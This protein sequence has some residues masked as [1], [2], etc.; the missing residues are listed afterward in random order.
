VTEEIAW[1]LKR[2]GKATWDTWREKMQ[3]EDNHLIL[4]GENNRPN[5][6]VRQSAV[7]LSVTAI[8]ERFSWMG[9]RSGYDQLYEHW[10]TPEQIVSIWRRSRRGYT[11]AWQIAG[12]L[13]DQ[14]VAGHWYDFS[15]VVAELR[16][17]LLNHHSGINVVHYTYLE[18]QLGHFCPTSKSK[19]CLVVATAHQPVSWWESHYN[20][21]HKLNTVDALIVLSTPALKF[22]E[23][24]LPG[25]V[26]LIR[27]GVD[28][29]F[30]H[31][32]EKIDDVRNGTCRCVFSG[33]WLRDLPT[34]AQVIRAFSKEDSRVHF[35]LIVRN[36]SEPQLQSLLALKNVKL[37]REITDEEL[38][39]VYQTGSLILLPLEDAT[40]NNALLEGMACGLPVISTDV[41]G[42][43]DYT[44]SHFAA[45][46]PPRD[47]EGMI[48]AINDVLKQP[49][50]WRARGKMARNFTVEELAWPK[51][52]NKT[53][54]LFRGLIEARLCE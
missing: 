51:I 33:S 26:H 52:A 50:R 20:P 10:N 29:D 39:T 22:F 46:F 30:F 6:I 45:L 27:H 35:D 21:R 44:H 18:N 47:V 7:K 11:R 41:G 36:T 5:G 31:P 38:R 43:R 49:D 16:A 48:G 4:K 14:S 53:S 28:V 42:L 13:F 15:S 8:R 40:A 17:N 54:A 25:R 3:I 9:N 12:R 2:S 24:I 32:S 19:R 1:N 34:L 23:Q 37:H